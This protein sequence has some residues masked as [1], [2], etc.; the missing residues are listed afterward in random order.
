MKYYQYIIRFTAVAI[1]FVL[2]ACGEGEED[3]VLPGTT[4]GELAFSVTMEDL[5]DVTTKGEANTFFKT[6]DQLKVTLRSSQ[7]G[8]AEETLTYVYQDDGVFRGNPPYYFP[9]DDSYILTLEAEWPINAINTGGFI[10]D[11]R[12]EENYREADWLLA[13]AS[14]SGVMATDVP[15]PLH[16]NHNN[17][18][19]EFELAG[20]NAQ[21]M[22]IE[23]LILDLRVDGQ[24][25]ACY[26]YCQNE[27]GRASLLLKDGTQLVSEANQI[28]GSLKV[29]D[30]S[31][32]YSILLDTVDMTLEAGKRYL[33]TLVS[34]GYNTDMYVFLGTFYQGT[35]ET[36]DGIGVPF[37][38]PDEGEM[39]DYI[40]HTPVQLITVSYVI[41]HYT[42]GST[43]QWPTLTYTLADDF[44]MTAE[45]AELYIP[46][47]ADTF[48][49]TIIYQGS[50]VTELPYNGTETLQLFE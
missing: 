2:F 25:T 28:I 5:V 31:S 19:L 30:N 33:V 42:D 23:E 16:F 17:C 40:I 9:L 4:S 48:T 18:L 12:E 44:E 1:S 22:A 10:A 7:S 3:Q 39:G 26:A 14:V 11:Q 21:G 20:Q 37:H 34:Q 13:T 41:R 45:Y 49:G 6:G 24:E 35:G 8:A 50:P 47:P 32:R 15:V 46:I 38:L 27:N 43:I 29:Q 36:E